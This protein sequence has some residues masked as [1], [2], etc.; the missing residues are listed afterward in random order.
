MKIEELQLGEYAKIISYDEPPMAIMA[1][2]SRSFTAREE[3]CLVVNLSNGIGS[4]HP[5]TLCEKISRKEA[6][7]LAKKWAKVC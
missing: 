3:C 1:L 7:K 5:G 4:F 6:F 2:S